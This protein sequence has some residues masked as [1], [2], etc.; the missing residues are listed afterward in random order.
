MPLEPED[1][2]HLTAAQGYV[3]LGMFLDADDELEK[4]DPYRRHFPEVL[5]VRVG[6]YHGLEKWELMEVVA[7][8][9]VAYEGT[10][11]ESWISWAYATRRTGSI[12]GAM[13]ILQRA[14][15]RNPEAAIIHYNLGCYACQKGNVAAAKDH[16]KRAFGIEPTLRLMAMDEEDLKPLWINTNCPQLNS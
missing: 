14:E 4:I 7:R 16:L 3:E 11:P 13:E 6:I 5:P 8:K 1:Q 15:R 9:W 2:K 10:N 12:D